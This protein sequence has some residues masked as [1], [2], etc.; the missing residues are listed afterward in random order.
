MLAPLFNR[1]HVTP[2]LTAAAR[3]ST[4]ARRRR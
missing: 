3:S 2:L 4:T 1:L